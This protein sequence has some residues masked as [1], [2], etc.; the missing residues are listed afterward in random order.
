MQAALGALDH[1][2]P[3]TD[4]A[5]IRS[6]GDTNQSGTKHTLE[7]DGTSPDSEPQKR[8]S[9]SSAT[10]KCKI[11]ARSYERADRLSRHMKTHENAR[12]HQCQ[13]CR[14]SFNRA[15]LL[16]RHMTTHLRHDSGEDSG[17][18][19]IQRAERAG[20]AC[21]AC[22]SAKAR[23]EDEKPCLR[24]RKRNIECKVANS[25][26]DYARRNTPDSSELD[27]GSV[28]SGSNTRDVTEGQSVAGA[29]QQ[30]QQRV[31][32]VFDKPST[33]QH[34]QDISFRTATSNPI[35]INNGLV[36]N[37]VSYPPIIS[38]PMPSQLQNYGIH[39]VPNDGVQL[40]FDNF[41]NEMLFTPHAAHFNNQDLN[42]NFNDLAFY[43]EQLFAFTEDN[44]NEITM[45][46]TTTQAPVPNRDVRAGYAAF[47]RSPWLWTPVQR[48][49]VLRDE[50]NLGLDDSSIS[51]LT[52]RSPAANY[53]IPSCGFPTIRH[54]MRDKMYYLVCTMDRRTRSIPSFPS[55]A[56]INHVV[57]AFFMRQTYQ[58]D[59]WIH[60]PSMIYQD[61]MP[62]FLMSLVVAGST[63]ISIPAIW[64]MGLVL[65][66]VVRVKLGEL[67]DRENS[68]TRRL[69]PLQAWML[70]LDAALWSGF[71]KQMELAESFL[72]PLITMMRRGGM[73]GMTADAQTLV[74]HE[75]DTGQVLEAKWKKWVH[76]ESFK[77]LAIHV[78][79]HDSKTSI[80][81]QKHHL[82]SIT[83]IKIS[84]PAPRSFFL[85]GSAL[86]WKV[87]FQ[88][89]STTPKKHKISFTDI[90]HDIHVLD[91]MYSEVD[92]DLCCAAAVHGFWG[93][94]WAFQ[95]SC[96]L[97]T[98][99]EKKDSVHRLWLL[100][101][102]RELYQQIESFQKSLLNLRISQRE[103]HVI[104]E[105]LLMMLH[106]SPEDLQGFAGRYGEEEASRAFV[107]LEQWSETES[108]R[109][110]VWHAGQ[111]FRW[112]AA[113]PSTE[114][115]DFYAIAVYF[116]ALC[117]WA[118]GHITF[119]KNRRE[120]SGMNSDRMASSVVINAE[121][122]TEVRSFITGRKL[123]PVLARPTYQR[124]FNETPGKHS[125]ISLDDPNSVLEMARELY[126]SNFPFEGESLPP[127]VE[128]MG[129][130]LRDLGSLPDSRF[131]RCASPVE[132]D[133][134]PRDHGNQ[135]NIS[136]FGLD[137]SMNL[138][139]L[140]QNFP[141][142]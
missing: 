77:R 3:S 96:R 111:I 22:A 104:I 135:S 14:K 142:I 42:I 108:A 127:L 101:Q 106:I 10:H 136:T 57:E 39:L 17:R 13:R 1:A 62:E 4:A 105:L 109:R 139:P 83:E 121:D 134:T 2:I 107:A 116:A 27:H 6:L 110:A 91:D 73:L 82:I 114:L 34:Q 55:L 29:A 80:A 129:N 133:T 38:E 119:S 30:A 99:W 88:R 51:A 28:S 35:G 5:T 48:D 61:V 67:F 125:L 23:C 123:N 75:S 72:E 126:K 98:I 117:L 90:M 45:A 89:Q 131:S 76:H 115:R 124:C 44:I 69:H 19:V 47:K 118:F 92:V 138:P 78:F 41:L 21:V 58:I 16:N 64:K 18:R 31:A 79:L 137:G 12:Q 46:E 9:Q 50:E 140:S 54:S 26:L 65:Q 120:F 112:A 11:C 37:R 66:D 32:N 95:E 71:K 59:N 68:A 24:C 52:P 141:P 25:S 94:I 122:T 97:H 53:N 85:A 36:G 63:V 102:Q 87:C 81:L 15:D 130:L 70:L 8:L 93:Q 132:R 33:F 40:G 20:Q 103:L 86:E 100:T 84:L 113:M 128:N 7:E 49:G 43:D 74:P 56:V 60:V